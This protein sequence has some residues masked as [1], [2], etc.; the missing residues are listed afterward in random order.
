MQQDCL[1][2]PGCLSIKSARALKG[3]TAFDYVCRL[4]LIALFHPKHGGSIQRQIA[5]AMD[6]RADAIQS[7]IAVE[8]G[9]L[10]R[11]GAPLCLYFRE[12]KLETN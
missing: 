11:A 1:S 7:A 12:A 3:I 6:Q 9:D 2:A 5:I 8:I 10:Q 4:P